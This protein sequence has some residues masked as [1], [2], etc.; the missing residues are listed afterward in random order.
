MIDVLN[1]VTDKISIEDSMHTRVYIDGSITETAVITEVIDIEHETFEISLPLYENNKSEKPVTIRDSRTYST[2]IDNDGLVEIPTLETLKGGKR[3]TDDVEG[4]SNLNLTVWSKLDS[5]YN[6]EPEFKSLL[7]TTYGYMFIFPDEWI[8]S[9]T[10]VY[11]NSTALLSFYILNDNETIGTELFSI[12]PFSELK[13][14]DNHN[15]YSK[16][17]S[18]GALIYGYRLHSN[19]YVSKDDIIDN[20]IIID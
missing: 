20:F 14:N 6:F 3:I 2:D 5:D 1:I 4:Y 15:S 7:N 10:A 16:I 19:S 9:I 11:N 13:W 12:L 17:S 18:H 8:D